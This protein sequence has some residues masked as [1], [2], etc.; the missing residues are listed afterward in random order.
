MPYR[1]RPSKTTTSRSSILRRRRHRELP[2]RCKIDLEVRQKAISDMVTPLKESLDKV[3]SKIQEMEKERVSAYT[4]LKEQVKTLSQT[5]LLLQSETSNLVK[6]LRAPS[7]RGQWGE[8]QLKRVVELS[9]MVNYCDFKEQVPLRNESCN[10]RPDMVIYLPNRK[11]IIV[12][13]KAPLSAYIDAIEAK[14]D[15]IKNEKLVD[16]ASQVKKH[17]MQLS[18][19]SYWQQFSDTPEFVV[20]FLPGETFFS[21]ALEKDPTLIEFGVERNVILATPTTLIALLKAVAYGWRQEQIAEMR[22]K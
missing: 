5:E 12:D 16:H 6:A 11:N 7:V 18:D 15:D 10:I 8:I 22:K 14:D 21:A 20:M 19:K 2:E 1:P 17:I 4:E 9:G 13:S 3:D